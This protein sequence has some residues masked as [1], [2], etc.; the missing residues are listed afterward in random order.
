MLGWSFCLPLSTSLLTT[1]FFQLS[2]GCRV[3]WG[4]RELPR[5]NLAPHPTTA[6]PKYLHQPCRGSQVTALFRVPPQSSLC[7]SSPLPTCFRPLWDGDLRSCVARL[8]CQPGC[9]GGATGQGAESGSSSGC[10][11]L[12]PK[13]TETETGR[14]EP[15]TARHSLL[16]YEL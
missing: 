2:G 10:V 5:Q 12:S 15:L 16:L 6:S 11:Q 3:P 8:S 4:V 7:E 14:R 1:L 13:E 9:L